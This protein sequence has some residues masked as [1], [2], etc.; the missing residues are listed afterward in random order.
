MKKIFE[1]KALLIGLVV[2]TILAIGV[3]I[4]YFVSKKDTKKETDNSTSQNSTLSTIAVATTN[5]SGS[6]GVV[7]A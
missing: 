6:G 7:Y 3:S 1:N 5:K 2:V 4:W